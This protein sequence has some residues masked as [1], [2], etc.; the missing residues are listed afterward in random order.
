MRL[1]CEQEKRGVALCRNCS[2]IFSLAYFRQWTAPTG[3][4]YISTWCQVC[5][6]RKKRERGR[7]HAKRGPE[8]I[9][10]V[11][12][13]WTKS[14]YIADA[15]AKPCAD[16]G[17][18]FPTVC[19]DFDHRPNSGKKFN[20]SGARDRN[21]ESIKAEIAKCDVVCA[22]CHRIRSAARKHPGSGR[23]RKPRYETIEIEL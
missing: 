15:K 10:R 11:N 12:S 17:R 20:L 22:C 9:P 7:A 14:Q 6:T 21:L 4:K 5:E 8:L 1:H 16:C 19:M 13:Y 18:I 23:P 3:E 2:E